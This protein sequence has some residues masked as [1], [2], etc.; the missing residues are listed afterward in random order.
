MAFLPEFR[1]DYGGE[2]FDVAQFMLFFR[3][4]NRGSHLTGKSTRNQRIERLWR[5]VFEHCLSSFYTL[6]YFLE[7]HGVLDVECE[8]QRFCLR[9]VFLPRIQR[10]F[11][12]FRNAWNYHQL[13]SASN[14]SP[15]QL[16]TMGMLSNVGSGYEAVDEVFS[17]Y[18][19]ESESESESE[20]TN[21][22]NGSELYLTQRSNIK[23]P[24]STNN[25]FN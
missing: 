16:W 2:N 10:A 7:D 8:I 14:Y 9:Y 18:V 3:G 20:H 11:D 13:S 22:D 6:F 21:S 23:F 12:S 24:L 15:M 1:S 19:G 17:A 25:L 5:D 4:T